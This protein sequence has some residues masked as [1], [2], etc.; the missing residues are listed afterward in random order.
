VDEVETGRTLKAGEETGKEGQIFDLVK[1]LNKKLIKE[2]ALRL[3][4]AEMA[5]LDQLKN[6][7]FSAV[8]LYSQAVVHEDRGDMNS[9]QTKYR[10][11]IADDPNF[12]LAIQ[13]LNALEKAKP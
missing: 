9:A 7:K 1:A 12:T 4:A 8:M 2:L 3:S 10:E 6:V 13:R 11:A 5:K